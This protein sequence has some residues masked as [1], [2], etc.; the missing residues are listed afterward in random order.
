MAYHPTLPANNSLV[1]S[2]E[3]GNQFNGL[4]EL[5]IGLQDQCDDAPHNT[6]GIAQLSLTFSNPLMFR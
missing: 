1:S 5:I 2:A 6:N 4:N 3:L